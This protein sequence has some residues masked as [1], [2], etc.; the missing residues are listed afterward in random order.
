MLIQ[1]SVK[2][3]KA[4]KD[5]ATLTFIASN[6]DKDVREQENVVNI[7]L[8]NL[9][10]L[11][12]AVIYGSNASGKTTILDA[13]YTMCQFVVRSVEG[14]RGHKI[15]LDPFRFNTESENEPTELEVLFYHKKVLY[16]YGF[17]ANRDKIIAEWLYHRPKKKEIELFYRQE[18]DFETNVKLFRKGSSIAKEGLVRDNALLLSTAAQ[19][20]DETA[21]LVLEWFISLQFISGLNERY[22]QFTIKAATNPE[23]RKQMVALLKAADLGIND[24]NVFIMD[25]SDLPDTMPDELK[26]NIRKKAKERNVSV[27]SEIITLHKKYDSKNLVVDEEPLSLEQ[28]ESEG[29]KKFFA[30]SGPILDVLDNGYILVID[31]FDSK[32]HPKLSEKLIA[33]F[34]NSETNPKGAQLIFNTHN[35]NLLDS[36]LFRRDQIWFTQKDRYG[37]AKLFS[38]AD[39]AVRKDDPKVEE[40]YL[41]GKFGAVPYL[42]DF[43]KAINSLHD[44][45]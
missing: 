34:N 35:T 37:A 12:S 32:L 43:E 10:L 24:I 16:R 21:N 2:N 19:F 3:Y 36:G 15:P 30:L 41:A 7:D 28:N 44:E 23:K 33:L 42:A 13:L 11:T 4:F 22:K 8:A 9:R 17:E 29:T 26:E 18:Q 45:E 6:Y 31:E 20:N 1:F 5:K 25:V 39:F 27:Y 40:K 14:Q 38:L